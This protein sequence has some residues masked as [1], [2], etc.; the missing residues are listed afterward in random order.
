MGRRNRSDKRYFII[1]RPEFFILLTY[2]KQVLITQRWQLT[3]LTENLSS[4]AKSRK[5]YHKQLQARS[6]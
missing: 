5:F 1:I 3:L 2:P 6:S 4:L